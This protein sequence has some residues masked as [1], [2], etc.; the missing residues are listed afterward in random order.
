M[1]SGKYE[2]VWEVLLPPTPLVSMVI[3]Y[4]KSIQLSS[5][6]PFNV[7]IKSNARKNLFKIC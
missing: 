7:V 6:I 2:N 5:S 3:C 4:L 1:Y